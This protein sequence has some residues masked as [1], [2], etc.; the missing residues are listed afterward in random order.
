[1]SRYEIF[2]GMWNTQGEV[3]P[4]DLGPASTL[5]AT[6][7]Y[8]WLPRRHFLLHRIDA[9]FGRAPTRGLEI[10]GYS[11]PTQKYQARSYDDQGS[12]ETFDVDLSG[13]RWRIFGKTVRFDGRFNRADDKLTGQWE[14]KS[15]KS[16][17]QP[18]IRLELVRI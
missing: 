9:R 16:G 10:I 17:W 14:L 7:T 6:D 15:Q 13:K 12:E 5:L 8:E 1:M 3:L 11:R 2:I 4:T 18:W